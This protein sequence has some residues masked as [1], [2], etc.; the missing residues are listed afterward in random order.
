MSIHLFGIPNCQTVKKARDWLSAHEIPY[1]F[2]DF[3]KEG[4]TESQLIA[5]LDK[6][7]LDQLINR[8]GMTYRNLSDEDKALTRS[9]N[10]AIALMR[11]YPSMIKRPV[12]LKE[13]HLFLG[14]K[15]S[16]YES[17]FS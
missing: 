6:V 16:E 12:L 14:F 8:S 9:M 4:I 2:H 1:E 13:N 5:W 11:N 3:K 7:S 15:P 10:E 17:I